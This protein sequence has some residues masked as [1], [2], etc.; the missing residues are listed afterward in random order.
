MNNLSPTRSRTDWDGCVRCSMIPLAA[1][2]ERT[3]RS[4][5]W[6][7]FERRSHAEIRTRLGISE[8]AAR[9]C[10][11]RALEKL[12]IHLTEN[13]V[14]PRLRP[15]GLALTRHARSSRRPPDC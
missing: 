1:L 6:R 4:N 2:S 12:R 10:V 15:L 7:F 11:E 5:Y 14:P 9:A 3:A 8:N 13:G